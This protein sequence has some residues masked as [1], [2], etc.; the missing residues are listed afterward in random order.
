M[1]SLF[2]LMLA[3]AAASAAAGSLPEQL[4]PEALPHYQLVTP[5]LA[6]GGQPSADTVAKLK[7]MGFKTVVN[8]RGSDEAPDVVREKAAVEAQGL[9]YVSIPITPDTFSSD[10]VEAVRR[11]LDDEQAAPILL[12][13]SSANRVGAVWGVIERRRG[14]SLAD[15][16]AEARKIGLSSP[17]MIEAFHK[18]ADAVSPAT[19]PMGDDKAHRAQVDHRHDEATGVP[20]EHAVH[21]FLLTKDGGSIS[22]EGRGGS[23]ARDQVREHL[24]AIARSFASGDFS[25]PMRIH[26]RVPPGVDVMTKRRAA[27]HYDYSPTDN[28]GIVRISTRDAEALAAIHEFV[29]FQIRDHGTNDP[30]D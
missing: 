14:S 7:E 13:C 20:H 18:I 2:G 22:L 11:I 21:H 9:R 17:A 30:T 25:M 28:G 23:A 3:A 8:L 26:D 1:K 24:Q 15:A 4:P 19:E 27:I 5:N 16:E 12:H 10:A 6:T 29:R